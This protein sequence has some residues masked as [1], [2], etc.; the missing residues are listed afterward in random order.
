MTQTP[1]HSYAFLS[2]LHP[3][4]LLPGERAISDNSW[5]ARVVDASYTSARLTVDVVDILFTRYLHIRRFLNR[6]GLAGDWVYLGTFYTRDFS[7]AQFDALTR[8]CCDELD[9]RIDDAAGHLRP[10]DHYG[11][12]CNYARWKLSD[13]SM[14]GSNV[15]R[16]SRLYSRLC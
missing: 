3:D 16:G 7:W 9:R 5:L 1:W 12:A 15:F 8:D 11:I 13:L 6:P 4:H 2:H 14:T 10:Q